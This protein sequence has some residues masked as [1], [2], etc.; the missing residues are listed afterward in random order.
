[1]ETWPESWRVYVTKLRQMKDSVWERVC[2][3]AEHSDTRFTVLAHGD[4]WIN[5]IMFNEQ[6]NSMRLVDFQLV[7]RTSPAIDLHLFICS[8]AT[9]DV[10]TN[11]TST[12]LQVGTELAK[13]IFLC[14]TMYSMSL[15]CGFLLWGKNIR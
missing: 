13:L 8:S 6:T 9:L 12:L 5:N 7:F 1:M 2:K 4:L 15:I 14:L 11:H 3:V 10:R